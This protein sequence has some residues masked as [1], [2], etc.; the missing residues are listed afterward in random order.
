MR[1]WVLRLLLAL[2]ELTDGRSTLLA[3]P[4]RADR[5]ISLIRR[6]LREQQP[7]LPDSNDDEN[8]EKMMT[9]YENLIL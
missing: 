6:V 9:I 4:A 8:V 7:T 2:S 1:V 5:L 3:T